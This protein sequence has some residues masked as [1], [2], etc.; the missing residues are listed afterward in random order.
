M[1]GLPEM[2]YALGSVL[3]ALL[4]ACVF[5]LMCCLIALCRWLSAVAE[6]RVMTTERTR[7][8]HAEWRRNVKKVTG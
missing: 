7:I 5:W 8:L 6:D 3:L 4:V 1:M 2:S